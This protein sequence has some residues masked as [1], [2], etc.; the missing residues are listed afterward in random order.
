MTKAI[1]IRQPWAWLIINAGKDIENRD[2]CT[3]LR[4]RV[5][6]HAAKG[7][8]HDEYDDAACTAA[9]A[10]VKNIPPFIDLEL[11]G[12][13][14]SVE[15]VDCVKASDSRWFFGKYGFVLRNPQPMPFMPW[16]GALGFFD[17]PAFAGP[18]DKHNGDTP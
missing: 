10:G 5:L 8:I 15:I 7:M 9:R 13:I 2:W 12:F 3:G 11:G 4:G 18:T 1:S 6:V 14:G 17:A 16:R